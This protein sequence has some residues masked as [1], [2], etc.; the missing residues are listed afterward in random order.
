MLLDDDEKQQLIEEVHALI[1]VRGSSHTNFVEVRAGPS[2]PSLPSPSFLI[3]LLRATPPFPP[4]RPLPSNKPLILIFTMCG[5]PDS[6]PLLLNA[7]AG[8]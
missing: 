5:G 2:L 3:S 7:V 1:S 8:V 6:L 4:H